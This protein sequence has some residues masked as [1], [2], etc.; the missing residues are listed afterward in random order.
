MKTNEVLQ[1]DVQ[2]AIKWEPFLNAAEIGVT[3]KEGV[4]TL[5]GTVDAYAK[6]IEAENA[7]K[8]VAGVRAVVE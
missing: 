7:V 3:V 4:V 8:K 6:K 2:D 5:T 1:R